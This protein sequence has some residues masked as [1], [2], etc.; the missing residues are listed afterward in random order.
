MFTDCCRKSV[1]VAE[2][3]HYCVA[4]RCSGVTCLA[5]ASVL[6]VAAC[7]FVYCVFAGSSVINSL[8]AGTRQSFHG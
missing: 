5:A 1:W 8:A 3:S 6:R 2:V 7:T 4:F